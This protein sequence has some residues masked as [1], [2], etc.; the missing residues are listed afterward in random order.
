MKFQQTF[1]FYPFLDTVVALVAANA[2]ARAT[3]V[4]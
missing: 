3:A 2:P 4:A 1:E